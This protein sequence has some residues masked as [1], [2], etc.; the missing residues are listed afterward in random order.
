MGDDVLLDRVVPL[1][2][3]VLLRE[4]ASVLSLSYERMSWIVP[5][6]LLPF[7]SAAAFRAVTKLGPISV[8]KFLQRS[9]ILSLPSACVSLGAESE[10]FHFVRSFASTFCNILEYL[11]KLMCIILRSAHDAG[12]IQRGDM[13]GAAKDL[14]SKVLVFLNAVRYGHAQSPKHDCY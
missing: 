13:A 11:L 6:F 14:V 3:C 5:G 8:Q 4:S 1:G 10:R 7:L 2:F 12:K 9:D